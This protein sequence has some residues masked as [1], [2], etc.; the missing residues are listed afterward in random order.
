MMNNTMIIL[1]FSRI[2]PGRSRVIKGEL[3]LLQQFTYIN[4]ISICPAFIFPK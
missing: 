1:E 4:C 3:N 2:L